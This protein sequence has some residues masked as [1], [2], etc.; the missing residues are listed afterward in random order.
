MDVVTHF[1]WR[2]TWLNF[3]F[4]PDD[5]FIVWD[6]VKSRI[7]SFVFVCNFLCRLCLSRNECY[8]RMKSSC[9]SF[10][11]HH[12]T[13]RC[14]CFALFFL[15]SFFTPLFQIKQCKYFSL[16]CLHLNSIQMAIYHV[17]LFKEWHTYTFQGV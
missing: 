8:R 13:N 16:L 9:T 17:I 3:P 10:D 2:N 5:N 12:N 4:Y 1:L 11:L 14:R 15:S 7:I 6:F